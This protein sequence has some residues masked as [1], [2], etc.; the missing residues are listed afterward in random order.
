VDRELSASLRDYTRAVGGGLIIGLP[1]LYTMEVWFQGFILPWW[2]QL[3]LLG[4]AFVVVLG[5]NSIAG[6]RRERSVSELVVD[7]VSTIGLGIV[8]AFV[9]LVVLGRI[10]IG[11]SLRDAAG[12]VALEAI[13]V[14]FGASLAATQLSGDESGSVESGGQAGPFHQLLVAA[15]G[16]LLFALNVAPTEEPVMLGIEASPLLLLVVM[17]ATFLL[18]YALVFYV[19]FGGRR[20]A[21]ARDGGVLDHPITETLM[22]YGVSIGVALLLLW[23]FGRTDGASAQAIA[24]MTVMLGVVAAVGAAIGRLLVGDEQGEDAAA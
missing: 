20:R 24:G 22:T 9:A 16:A 19:D 23:A 7:S 12:K 18:T 6:F 17:A 1:L 10:E 2:K 15:G 8:V 14:A 3:L 21:R 11:T 5:Y 13:P 4:I